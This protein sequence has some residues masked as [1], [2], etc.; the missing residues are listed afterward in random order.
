M[1]LH[2]V[3]FGVATAI[4]AAILWLISRLLWLAAP[5]GPI[6]ARGYMMR[7]GGHMAWGG[8]PHMYALGWLGLAAGLIL[9]PLIA[10]LAAWG[11]A[12][13]YNWLLGRNTSEVAASKP[14]D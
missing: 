12:A 8:H 11:T 9:W 13:I 4:V 10:G 2:A 6:G 14:T 3:K 5:V 1:K 7:G